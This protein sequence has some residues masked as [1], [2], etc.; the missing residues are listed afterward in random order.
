MHYLA[1]EDL[2]KSI[3]IFQSQ[4]NREQP[5]RFDVLYTAKRAGDLIHTRL[6]RK[7]SWPSRHL[8]DSWSLKGLSYQMHSTFGDM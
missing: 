7:S 6:S 3:L 5:L 2:L 1:Q 4:K 8:K